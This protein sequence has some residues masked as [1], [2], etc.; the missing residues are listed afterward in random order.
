MAKIRVHPLSLGPDQYKNSEIFSAFYPLGCLAAYAKTAFD[1]A[2]GEK[3]EFGHVTPTEARQVPAVLDDVAREP[4]IFLLSSYVWNH[5]VNIGF[6]KQLKQRSPESLVIVGGPHVPRMPVHCER[7]FDSHPY[8]DVAVRHEGEVTLAELLKTVADARSSPEGLSSVDLSDVAGLSFRKNGTIA[9]T[10]DRGR[11][12]DLAV[13]PSPYTTG[14]YDHWIENRWYMPIESN[15]GCPYGCTFCDWGA[16]TLSKIARVSMERVLGEV[17]FAAKNRIHTIGFCDANFGILER[18]LEI[19]RYI[20]QTRERTGYPQDVGYTNAKTAKPRLGEIIKL[21]RDAGLTAAAQ[22]SMQ[23]TDEQVL[24]NVERANIKTSEYRKMIAFFH[25]QD[26]PT[27]SDMM[28][29]LPGQTYE[30]CKADLQFFFDH[31]VLA[32]IFATSVM[33]NAPMADADYQK[34]FQISVGADGMVE[35]T[36]SFTREGYAQMFELCL[37]YKLFVKLGLLKYLLYFVQREHGVRAMDFVSK[38]LDRSSERPDLY[39]ISHRIKNDM[40][41]RDYRGGR[42]DWLV[43]VWNDDQGGVVFEDLDGFYREILS[44]FANEHGVELAG[45][46]VE[47]VLTANREV[48]PHKGR[49]FPAR[50]PLAH[51][52]PGYFAELRRLPSLDTASSA[53]ERLAQRGPAD[54]ELAEQPAC[55]SYAHADIGL[56]YGELELGS[57]L[58]I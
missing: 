42:K 9:R 22:I 34:R 38:W 58:R 32:V 46:D 47:A 35:S 55:L 29:G 37:A 7:F 33:P 31:K 53:A 5:D 8:V 54:L 17:D 15:R 18:D 40:I 51:D 30:T 1:G 14:E 28:L 20:V 36:Y 13:Y 57:N 27:V 56:T 11:T 4:G 26:I 48:M 24:A 49:T 41:G 44:F 25:Q 3:F 50:V 52:V 19:V 12:M 2:L 45:S 39:P 21:L 43:L 16:A 10:P 23:T 6:A